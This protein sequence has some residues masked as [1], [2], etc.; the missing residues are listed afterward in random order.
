MRLKLHEIELG[1]ENVDIT[2]H[3]FQ[4]VLGLVP[5]LKQEGLTVFDAG[6]KG[7]DFNVS[8][9][10]SA[11]NIVLSFFTDDLAAVEEQ[12]T[13]IGISIQGPSPSHLGMTSIQFHSPEGFCIKINAAGSESPDRL[14]L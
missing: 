8:N 1:T 3:F 2:T 11:G 7:L 12:L 9:H 6:L 5:S 10:L 14:T 4:A 13:K